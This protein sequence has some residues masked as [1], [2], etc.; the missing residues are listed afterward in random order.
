MISL[1][2]AWYSRVGVP[3]AAMREVSWHFAAK[4]FELDL[5]LEVHIDG[6]VLLRCA[7]G[8]PSSLREVSD[9]PGDK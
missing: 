1:Y 2:T 3:H 8:R 7:P 5:H 4:V 6:E 9:D